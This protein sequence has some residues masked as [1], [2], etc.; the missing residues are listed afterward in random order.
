[1]RF[2]P[3][4]PPQCTDF[5]FCITVFFTVFLPRFLLSYWYCFAVFN[6]SVLLCFCPFCCLSD[7]FLFWI[8]FCFFLFFS[9][10]F[11]CTFYLFF[12][13][14]LLSFCCVS[15]VRI[16]HACCAYLTAVWLPLPARCSDCF[17]IYFLYFLRSC[18]MI[19]LWL[20]LLSECVMHDYCVC[21]CLCDCLSD[22][23]VVHTHLPVCACL[24]VWSCLLHDWLLRLS[25]W[26]NDYCMISVCVYLWS[27]SCVLRACLSVVWLSAC[28]STCLC[29]CTFP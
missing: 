26:L 4:S 7:A 1:M 10:Y 12:F 15:C 5:V 22:W 24:S 17:V 6:A 11:N 8:S 25:T 9:D 29:A 3:L 18:L 23:V 28:V 2:C 16:V 13:Y 20:C 19:F 27:W 14:N 21:A